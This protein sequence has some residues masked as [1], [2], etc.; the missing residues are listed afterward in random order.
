MLRNDNKPKEQ[1][2]LILPPRP[3]TPKLFS[4]ALAASGKMGAKGA[5]DGKLAH[6]RARLKEL[7]ALEAAARQQQVLEQ[8]KSSEDA[9]GETRSA[10]PKQPA[11]PETPAPGSPPPAS[12][13][14][15]EG[16]EGGAAWPEEHSVRVHMS[17]GPDPGEQILLVE[18]PKKE[19]KEEEEE[20]LVLKLTNFTVFVPRSS[21]RH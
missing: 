12:Q 13:G 15:S 7:A 4:A 10:T 5:K 8:A 21:H 14:R 6:L 1:S 18:I 16:E 2:V 11:A 17:P 3:G 9:A 19:E 20:G